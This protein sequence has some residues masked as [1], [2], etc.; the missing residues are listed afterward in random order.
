MPSGSE[1][2]RV[3]VADDHPLY[4]EGVVRALKASGQIEVVAEAEDGRG[5][6]AALQEHR[7]QVAV[8]DYKLPGLDGL[9]VT[10]A[11]VRDGLATRVLLLSALTDGGIVYKALETGAAGY[12]AKEAR[13]EEI[14]DAVL[15][16][17]RGENI[18]SSELASGL[19]SEIRLRS[20]DDS[21]ILTDREHEILKLVA[22][23]KSLPAIAKE[24]YL[25]VTTVKTHAQHVYAK[26]GVSDR[27]AAVAEA[28]RH[29]LIE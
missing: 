6:L 18:L 15:A 16:C 11:V 1:K 26:L 4:R 27:A 12:L 22:A 9:A 3:V 17:A 25:G 13:R 2:V 7:P 21:P 5:A 10:H 8:L 14:V 28:M 29:G 23:G 24:L 19:V 20:H